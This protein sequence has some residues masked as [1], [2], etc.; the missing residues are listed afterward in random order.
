M[1][2][3]TLA[4]GVTVVS[5]IALSPLYARRLRLVRSARLGSAFVLLAVGLALICAAAPG[6]AIPPRNV[7]FLCVFV[8]MLVGALLLFGE[9]PDDGPDRA[10]DE[11]PWWPEFEAGLRR[12]T[13]QHRQLIPRR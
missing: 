5:A 10:D 4:L 7:L 1:F 11:P 6:A 2:I 13:R 3:L 9:D 12:Y 8:L